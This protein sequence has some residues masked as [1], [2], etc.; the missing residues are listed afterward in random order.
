MALG[1]SISNEQT[2]VTASF[3]IIGT[4]NVDVLNQRI[5]VTLVGYVNKDIYERPGGVPV[6]QRVFQFDAAEFPGIA[7]A[8]PQGSTVFEVIANALYPK[9]RTAQR[10]NQYGQPLPSEFADAEDV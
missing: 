10:R 4:F 9:I 7:F 6:D 3:W 8:A 5:N 1:I 2:G